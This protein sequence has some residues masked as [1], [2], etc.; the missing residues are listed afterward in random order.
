MR[1]VSNFSVV[2]FRIYALKATQQ[3][4]SFLWETY[5]G[6]EETFRTVANP[7]SS[8]ASA[9][10]RLWETAA[11]AW[12]C[13]S[14]DITYVKITQELRNCLFSALP[15]S[16]CFKQ[17]ENSSWGEG[18][19]IRSRWKYCDW[20]NLVQ[21]SFSDISLGTSSKCFFFTANFIDIT[22]TQQFQFFN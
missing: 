16:S 6:A 7:T 20:K 19:V 22:V 18:F 13:K 10:V 9:I 11:L 3:W 14:D 17:S 4:M 8:S 12:V 15:S 21:N 1:W 2:S 5:A